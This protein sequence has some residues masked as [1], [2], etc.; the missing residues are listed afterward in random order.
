MASRRRSR[1]PLVAM[2]CRR[3]TLTGCFASPKFRRN[4][5]SA[6]VVGLVMVS[7][8]LSSAETGFKIE[9]GLVS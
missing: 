2:G 8:P 3:L 6:H 9:T 5:I 7:K 1:Q 4:I